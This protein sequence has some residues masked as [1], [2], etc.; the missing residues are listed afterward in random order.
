[1][2]VVNITGVI[3]RGMSLPAA[4]VESREFSNITQAKQWLLGE[5]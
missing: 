3:P 5:P 1:M 2:F 4:P